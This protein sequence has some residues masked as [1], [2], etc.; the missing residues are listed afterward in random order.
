VE[1]RGVRNACLAKQ[2]N[3]WLAALLGLTLLRLILAAVIPLSP[4]ET[5]YWLWSANLQPGYFDHPPMVA[6]WIRAGTLLLGPTPLGVRFLGPLAA[7]VGS[8]LLWRAGEDLFPK[9]HAGLLAAAFLNATL[10]LGVG[11]IIMTPDTPLLFFWIGAVA[12]CG[13]WVATRDARWWLAIGAAAGGAMLSK[14]TAVFLVWGVFCWLLFRGEGRA[15][16]K[17]PWPWAA[18]LIAACIFA[19]NVY[20]NATHGWVS[21]LKQGSR[22]TSFDFSRSEQFLAELLAGQFALATPL[23]AVMAG[24]G[25]WRLR[26]SS[27]AGPT[28]ITWLTFLPAFAFVGHVV[29][30]RVQANWPA[31]IY[32]ACCLAAATLPEKMVLRWARPA[33]G[34]GFAITLLAYAQ[35]LAAPLPIPAAWD[36]AALQLSGWPQLAA[37]AAAANPAFVTS[38]DYATNAELAYYAPAGVEVAGI[39]ARWHYL[40]MNSSPKLAGAKGIMLTRHPDTIC[41]DQLGTLTRNRGGD[42]IGSYRL[43]RITAP[44]GAILLPRP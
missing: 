11:A 26:D 32:P 5:Y 27:A 24:V 13:R 15:A 18:M 29:S 3:N 44:A 4:D 25:F 20:W 33:L 9:R 8:V 22:V 2:V 23:V 40:G 34:L 37:E 21:Y 14:Y 16:L 41:P 35:A 19:P 30:D 1:L 10:M 6:F 36:P 42:A 17:T 39:G 43:C 28:L 31:V 12:A 38:D 7:A